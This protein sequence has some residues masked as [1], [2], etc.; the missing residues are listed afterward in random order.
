MPFLAGEILTAAR[1]NDM[2]LYAFAVEPTDVTGFTN[3]AYAPGTPACGLTFVAPTSGTVHILMSAR[4]ESNTAGVRA[5]VSFGVRT[6]GTIGSGTV[7]SASANGKALTTP[8]DATGGGNQ[9][10]AG[11]VFEVVQGL[12]GGNTYNVQTEHLIE[13]A[14]N[15]DIFDRGLIV[16]GLA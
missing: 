6:G 11:S 9:R 4:F 7:V 16:R 13:S 14:G 10:A 8:T 5:L 15:G 2:A 12:T 1:L 3:T